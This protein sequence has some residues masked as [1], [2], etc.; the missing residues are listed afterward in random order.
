MIYDDNI[1][2]GDMLGLK[3]R[4]SCEFIQYCTS[5]FITDVSNVEIFFN[6][7]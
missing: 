2:C 7:S 6:K 1:A 4:E 5:K 3:Q